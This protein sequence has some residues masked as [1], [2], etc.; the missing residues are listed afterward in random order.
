MEMIS[1]VEA[2]QQIENS[3]AFPPTGWTTFVGDDDVG[4]LN[5]P[6]S[7]R[8]C[9][10]LLRCKKVYVDLSQLTSTRGVSSGSLC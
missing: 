2:A 3:I 9:C 5:V 10:G 1:F 4:E 7:K 8:P 6:R